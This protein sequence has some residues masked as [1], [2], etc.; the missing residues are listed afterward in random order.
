MIDLDDDKKEAAKE[1]AKDAV[2]GFFLWR[3]I[4]YLKEKFLDKSDEF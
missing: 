1:V 2:K 3:G 4:R